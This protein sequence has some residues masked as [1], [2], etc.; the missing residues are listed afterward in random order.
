M[1]SGMRYVLS[2]VVTWC[3][4]LLSSASFPSPSNTKAHRLP[5]ELGNEGTGSGPGVNPGR[6]SSF[7]V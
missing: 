6:R 7:V 4:L 2:P 1:L 3:F 5:A